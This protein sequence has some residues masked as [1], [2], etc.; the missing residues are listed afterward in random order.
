M[1]TI[2]MD[3]LKDNQEWIELKATLQFVEDKILSTIECN[4]WMMKEKIVEQVKE[5]LSDRH[6]IMGKMFRLH[7]T[8]QETARFREVNDHLLK[9]TRK[10]FSEHAKLLDSLKDNPI[11]SVA[12]WDDVVVESILDVDE[13][14]EVLRYDDDDDYGSNFSQMIDAI[15]WT[16]DLEIRSCYTT[17]GEKSE[18]DHL[19]NSSRWSWAEGCFDVPQ[20]EGIG[21]C[22]AIHDLCTHKNYSVPDLLRIPSYSVLNTV[23]G[24]RKHIV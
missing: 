22:Y 5:L 9:L 18:P 8:D 23:K 15:A 7:V 20:F 16:E 17:L 4:A 13:D 11:L 1:E 12:S 14:A 19:D 2:M 3:A 24:S 21:V 10:M 6:F